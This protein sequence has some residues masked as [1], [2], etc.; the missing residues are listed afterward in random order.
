MPEEYMAAS[1]RERK[2]LTSESLAVLLAL[3]LL[4][5]I[6]LPRREFS[7]AL[8]LFL[9]A[10]ILIA[11]ARVGANSPESESDQE[12]VSES[13]WGRRLSQLWASEPY[14]LLR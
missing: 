2:T 14:Q 4:E 3:V 5:A 1:T 9:V 6:I 11:A 12:R 7:L 13:V 8:H 10:G